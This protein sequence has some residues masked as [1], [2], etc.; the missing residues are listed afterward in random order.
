MRNAPNAEELTLIKGCLRGDQNAQ[1]RLYKKYI[2]A[3]YNIVIR[4]HPH[5]MD[6]EDILQDSFVK[7]FRNLS[8]LTLSIY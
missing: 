1:L 4:M 5:P 3:M 6:A 8:S 2:Q 7:V